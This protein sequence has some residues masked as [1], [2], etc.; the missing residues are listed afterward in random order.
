MINV[1][2]II[3]KVFGFIFF[4][5]IIKKSNIIPHKIE[6]LFNQISFNFLL[7]LALVINFWTIEF[8]NIFISKLFFS[9]FGSGI[10]IFFVSF[11]FSKFFF[12]FKTDNSALF[13]LAA[14]FGNSVALGIPLMYSILGPSKSMP[15]M[16]LVL[17][18]GMVHFTYTTLIIE[19]YRNKDFS[20]LNKIFKTILGLFKNIILLGMIIGFILN[21][22]EI[23]FSP[24]LQN[25][26]I[27][28]SKIAIPFVLISM[29]I[30]LGNYKL[31][32]N[33]YYSLLLTSLK[34]FL[35]PCLAF[36]LAKYIFLMPSNLVFIVTIAAALPS[37]TQTY[38]FS[39]R[40]NAL[41]KI[42]STNVVF[43]TFISFF[44]LSAIL[45]FLKF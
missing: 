32:S 11:F 31:S 42:L 39:Y 23:P 37:G 22:F 8:P 33:I 27:P 26:L 21:Y 45:I 44:T 18:H 30:S 38:Y 34:N 40:Y 14:C 15:Y 4:G 29:G 7:P 5:Y 9:F 35:H 2:I 13:G 36:I 24:N 25:F 20:F 12:N 19:A 6:K 28:I 41:E 10:I 3:F 43:S 16:I 1:L 17:F